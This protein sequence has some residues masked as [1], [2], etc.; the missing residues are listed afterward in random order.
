MR[1][2]VVKT[3][4][5]YELIWADTNTYCGKIHVFDKMGAK[6]DMMFHK[7]INKSWFVN[8]GTFT[9]RWIDTE[10]GKLLEQTINEGKT[11]HIPALTPAN[12]ESH[13]KDGSVTECADGNTSLDFYKIIPANNIGNN[14]VPQIEK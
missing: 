14:N 8:T 12:L 13:V 6:T 11:F 10:S 3:N 5:G 2:N 7:D 9:V 1:E 4:Y